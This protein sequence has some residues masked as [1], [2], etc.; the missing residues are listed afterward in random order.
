M[1]KKVCCWK[2]IGR[3]IHQITEDIK[4][5]GDRRREKLDM[6]IEYK[7]CSEKYYDIHELFKVSTI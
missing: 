3:L 7:T 4:K 1:M 6:V 5:I 2:Q